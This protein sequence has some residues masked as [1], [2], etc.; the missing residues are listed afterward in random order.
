MPA[1]PRGCCMNYNGLTTHFASTQPFTHY[2]ID[3]M[4]GFPADG[5][6]PLRYDGICCCVD[7]FSKRLIAIPVWEA[8]PA[9]V[10]AD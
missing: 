5:G 8:S 10:I 1:R 4:F 3:F 2:S 6:G 9:E 7:M